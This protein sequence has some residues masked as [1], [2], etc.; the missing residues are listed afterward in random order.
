MQ[1]ILSLPQ[2]IEKTNELHKQ[3]KQI[4]VAGGCF[5]ILHIGHFTFLEKAKSA[6]NALFVLLESDETI[7][8]S[9]GPNRPINTQQNRAKLLAGLSA[10]DFV[11]LLPPLTTNEDY[12]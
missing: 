3:D 6:G 10:V 5:D 11:I 2:A 4:V 7:K 12:D 8:K 9:K 1:K